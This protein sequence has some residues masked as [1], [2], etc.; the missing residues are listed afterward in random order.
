MVLWRL[1]HFNEKWKKKHI[2]PYTKSKGI[3]IMVWAAVWG[4]G[5]TEI[6]RTSRDEEF[7]PRGYLFFT[8]LFGDRLSK[9]I[10]L[11]Y[12]NLSWF[13]EHVFLLL[14]GHPTHLI[15]TLLNMPGPS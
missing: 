8:V 7:A 1:N 14:T 3:S 12:G 5:H 11:L 13:D 6:Y 4:G 2:V 10:Y 9:I 15:W